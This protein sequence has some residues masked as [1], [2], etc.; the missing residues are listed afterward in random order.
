MGECSPLPEGC[1]L[2]LYQQVPRACPWVSTLAESAT[3]MPVDELSVWNDSR[4]E[5]L[6]EMGGSR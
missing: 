6:I 5:G 1:R 4:A 2:G 3:D